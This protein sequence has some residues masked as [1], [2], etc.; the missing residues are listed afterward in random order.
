MCELS[1][2]ELKW[3]FLISKIASTL[4]VKR[5]SVTGTLPESDISQVKGPGQEVQVSSVSGLEKLWPVH[6]GHGNPQCG[7]NVG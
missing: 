3:L 7:P 6:Q 4:D 5:S 2:Q 1:L